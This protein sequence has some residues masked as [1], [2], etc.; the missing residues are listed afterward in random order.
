MIQVENCRDVHT[1]KVGSTRLKVLRL[2]FIFER[3]H[4]AS[5]SDWLKRQSCFH[6]QFGCGRW[7]CHWI[8]TKF[9]P[10]TV[11]MNPAMSYRGNAEGWFNNCDRFG[12]SDRERGQELTGH[13]APKLPCCRSQQL[14]PRA[15]LTRNGNTEPAN[16]LR[17][18]AVERFEKLSLSHRDWLN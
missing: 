12:N 13:Q 7:H 14:R 5:L 3:H 10:P 1:S 2:V 11:T 17:M 18:P 15:R 6:W 4:F 16:V 8:Q 9:K